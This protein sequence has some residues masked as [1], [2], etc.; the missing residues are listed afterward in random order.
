MDDVEALASSQGG[1]A[2]RRAQREEQLRTRHDLGQ[3]VVVGR[4]AHQD[5]DR[6]AGGVELSRQLEDQGAHPR[7]VGWRIGVGDDKDPH[8]G[9]LLGLR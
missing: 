6:V 8:G 4:P 9:G 2:C 5:P 1:E 3:P 7:D